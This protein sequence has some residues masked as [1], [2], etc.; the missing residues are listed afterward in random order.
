MSKELV[1][2]VEIQQ[3][4]RAID[5]NAPKEPT[6]CYGAGYTH[7]HNNDAAQPIAGESSCAETVREP[8]KETRDNQLQCVNEDEAGDPCNVLPFVL[9]QEFVY[10]LEA[11]QRPLLD[12]AAIARDTTSL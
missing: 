11:F 9:G 4:G 7:D 3:P 6:D 8:P 12:S 2:Q 10:M 5:E 1:P